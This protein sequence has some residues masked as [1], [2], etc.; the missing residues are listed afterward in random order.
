M[1]GLVAVLAALLAIGQCVAQPVARSAN[2][3][4]AL[5]LGMTR[6]NV[7]AVLGAPSSTEAFES[8]DGAKITVWFYYRSEAEGR[9]TL[10]VPLIFENGKLVAWGRSIYQQK[11]N[12]YLPSRK[13]K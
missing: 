13:G 1:R 3:F 8:V 12:T 9:A 10:P 7:S 4:E 5:A 11:L 2:A 6:Q